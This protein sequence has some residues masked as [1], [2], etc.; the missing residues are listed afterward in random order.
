MIHKVNYSAS[1]AFLCLSRVISAT[2]AKYVVT[3]MLRNTHKIYY[4]QL[5]RRDRRLHMKIAS[6]TEI[7]NLQVRRRHRPSRH[8]AAL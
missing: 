8:R 1:F 3:C 7:L 6:S 5:Q 2:Y 4:Q